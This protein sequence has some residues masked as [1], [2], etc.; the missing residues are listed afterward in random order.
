MERVRH[1]PK[2]SSGTETAAQDAP[3]DAAAATAV[4]LAAERI[5]TAQTLL[6]LRQLELRVLTEHLRTR[7]EEGGAFVVL[8]VDAARGIVRRVPKTD[9]RRT[10]GNGSAEFVQP[11]TTD[12]Q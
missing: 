7:Y 11:T 2:S 10:A 9:A 12:K 8:E 4:L 3:L 1:A 5:T 6:S